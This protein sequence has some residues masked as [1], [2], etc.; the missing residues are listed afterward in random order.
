MGTDLSIKATLCR[1][2]LHPGD[3]LILYTDGITE[4]KDPSGEEFGLERFVQFILSHNA[5]GLPVPETLRRL[6]HSVLDYQKGQLQDDATVLF[7]EWHGPH[8]S[9]HRGSGPPE[10]LL[11]RPDQCSG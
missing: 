11:S 1:E 8:N 6:V 5:E 10:A 2:Q 4:A 3:R 9:L 7:M